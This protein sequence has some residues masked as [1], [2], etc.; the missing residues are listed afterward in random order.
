MARALLSTY[1]C[2]NEKVQEV[3]RKTC[4]ACSPSE[5]PT[6]VPTTTPSLAPSSYPTELPTDMPTVTPTVVPTTLPP[7]T[8]KVPS[9]VPSD[10]PTKLPSDLPTAVQTEIPTTLPPTTTARPSFVP[11]TERPTATP[12]HTPTEKCK[13]ASSEEL[14]G[15]AK[16]FSYLNNNSQ[17]T[18]SCSR[19]QTNGLCSLTVAEGGWAE[20][21][22]QR[23]LCPRTCGSCEKET[24]KK[25]KNFALPKPTNQSLQACGKNRTIPVYNVNASFLEEAVDYLKNKNE[26]LYMLQLS[27]GTAKLTKTMK[28]DLGS[29]L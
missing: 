19:V 26:R 1:R 29:T 27:E 28:F 9:F 12:S 3:C 4:D 14:T 5:P 18:Y 25:V 7:T 16:K 11:S 22:W 10:Y 8:T 15:I 2:N 24:D 20:G 23:G 21:R 17:D 6:E 13:D